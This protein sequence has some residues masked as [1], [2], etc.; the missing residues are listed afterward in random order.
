VA[1]PFKKLTTFP[2]HRLMEEELVR[3]QV[4]ELDLLASFGK[5]G[6]Q[7]TSADHEPTFFWDL[8]WPCGLVAALQFSQLTQQVG[9]RLD[10]PEVAHALRHLS[11]H[12]KDEWLLEQAEPERFAALAP[13]VD[14]NWELWRWDNRGEKDQVKNGLAERD[15][16]CWRDEMLHGEDGLVYWVMRSP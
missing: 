13:S 14:R 3:G 7:G 16:T 4:S 1:R 15:A 10:R 8:E 11:L 2:R 9:I 5:P 6:H 12:V